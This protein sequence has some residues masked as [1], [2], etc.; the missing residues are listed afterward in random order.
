M[1]GIV[2]AVETVLP[3]AEH[4]F[5]VRH[6]HENMKL[7]WRGEAYKTML[8]KCATAC[9]TQEF[10]K[11]MDDLKKFNNEAYLWLAK[12]PPKHWSRSHFS[13]KFYTYM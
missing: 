8:W 11:S 6:I 12:M 4:R 3:C 9:T 5:C 10:E 7:R 13:G 1:Q 2:H